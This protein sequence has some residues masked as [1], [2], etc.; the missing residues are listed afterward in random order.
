MILEGTR[1]YQGERSQQQREMQVG[2][3]LPG[4]AP[5]ILDTRQF[6][7]QG[8]ER[9]LALALKGL[10]L[11]PHLPLGTEDSSLATSEIES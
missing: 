6:P 11:Q 4:S 1:R 5:R 3:L 10:H 8:E 7:C 2:S 9:Q